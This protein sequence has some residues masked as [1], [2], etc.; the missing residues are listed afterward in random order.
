[1]PTAFSKK[2]IAN[3]RL[4]VPIPESCLIFPTWVELWKFSIKDKTLRLTNKPK[5]PHVS[6]NLKLL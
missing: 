5:F 4:Y 1:M 6:R 2:D 3:T